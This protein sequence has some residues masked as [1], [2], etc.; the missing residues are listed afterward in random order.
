[1]KRLREERE[2]TRNFRPTGN[3]HYDYNQRQS[4]IL[5]STK[6]F[7][8]IIVHHCLEEKHPVLL[9]KINGEF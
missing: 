1:M 9:V 3:F 4:H 5:K 7:K 8:V 6:P 2:Q